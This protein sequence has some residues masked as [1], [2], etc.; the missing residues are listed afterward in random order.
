MFDDKIVCFVCFLLLKW[1]VFLIVYE[2][3][4][5]VK[6]EVNLNFKMWFNSDLEEYIVFKS[7]KI[8]LIELEF[9]F[10]ENFDNYLYVV[11]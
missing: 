4:L 6:I 1:S 2:K 7:V 5:L 9:N 8:M 10:N 3:R 11:S